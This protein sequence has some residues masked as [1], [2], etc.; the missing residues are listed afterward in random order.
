MPKV[1]Y[2]IINKYII[3]IMISFALSFISGI[4]AFKFFPFFPFIIIALCI[5][6]VFYLFF[7]QREN[8]KRI[9]LIIGSLVKPHKWSFLRK[10]ESRKN[11]WKTGFPLKDCGN[12][13][14][15]SEVF[16]IRNFLV[17]VLVF[18]SGFFWSLIRAESLPD[19]KFPD[20]EV[21]VQGVV[22]DVPEVSGEKSRFTIDDVY[23]EGRHIPGKIR[24][25]FL[26]EKEEIFN[27]NKTSEYLLPAYGDQVNAIAKLREPNVFH[28]PG[29]YSY[30]FKKDGIIAAGYVKHLRIVS[31]GAGPLAWLYKKRQSLG[32]IID[33]SL[34]ADNAA[35][36]KAIIIGFQRGIAQDIRDDFSSTGL[37][38]I[39]SIS[40]TH[41]GLLAFIFFKA[42]KAIVKLLPVRFLTRLTLYITPTQTAI[43]LTLPVMVL[44]TLISGSST[45]A[46]RSFIMALIYMLAVFIGRKDQ[47]LNS[48][49]IAA[50]I[51]L[52]YQPTALLNCHS[53]FLLLQCFQ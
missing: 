35:F 43:L 2:K 33:S 9:F 10:Q 6:S 23:I 7:K 5:M 4:A 1:F 30:D 13:E 8:K 46:I 49:S 41:F 3:S 48:L 18:V 31:N 39:L 20:K 34:T 26:S 36:Q 15:R 51:I 47:W 52:L 45:P 24:L 32:R 38:H 11:N 53:S 16:L 14:N 28:N 17:V 50:I 44:Y 27:K 42:L 22:I 40:G 37:A 29:V 12:D 25:S 21:S 19:I